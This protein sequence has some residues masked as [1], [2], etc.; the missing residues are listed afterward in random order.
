MWRHDDGGNTEL[1]R[2]APGMDRTGASE[3]HESEVGRV[4]TLYNRQQADGICHVCGDH[5]VNPERRLLRG[6]AKPVRDGI[7]DGRLA[8]LRLQLEATSEGLGADESEEKVGVRHRGERTPPAVAGRSRAR[9]DAL[10]PHLQGSPDVHIGHTPP[11]GPDRP[12]LQDRKTQRV[13]GEAPLRSERRLPILNEA[14][15][16]ARAPHVERDAAG[17]T[18]TLRQPCCSHDARCRPRQQCLDRPAGDVAHAGQAAVRLH[19]VERIRADVEPLVD[20]LGKAGQVGRQHGRNVRIEGG[21]EQPP[22][23]TALGQD[24]RRQADRQVRDGGSQ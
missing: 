24:I 8:E 21:H 17:K 23:L 2:H 12:D 22:I 6:Q 18:G 11:S 13:A 15:V 10:R 14:D 20:C 9:A 19:D 4:V 1:S 7:A 5:G 3:R 16:G